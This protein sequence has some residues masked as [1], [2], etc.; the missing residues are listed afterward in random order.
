MD[1]PEDGLP[2]SALVGLLLSAAVNARNLLTTRTV[3]GLHAE[4]L[5]L[6]ERSVGG[7]GSS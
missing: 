2:R 5:D 4:L 6:I 3:D 1:A 7:G